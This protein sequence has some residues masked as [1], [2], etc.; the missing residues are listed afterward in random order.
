MKVYLDICCLKRPFDDQMQPRIALE[1]AAVLTV[2]RWITEGHLAAVR[3]LAHNLENSL[4]PNVA[5]AA[6]VSE[7][8]ELLNPLEPTPSAVAGNFKEFRSKGIGLMDAY[9][10]AWAEYLGADVFLTSDDEFLARGR[11]L[12]GVLKTRMMDPCAFVRG[13]QS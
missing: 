1:T 6:V 11:R 13:T 4:N 9:H 7:W 5:R 2:L 8:L 12:S 3:S 10:L